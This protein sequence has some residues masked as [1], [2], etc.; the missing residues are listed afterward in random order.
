MGQ[1]GS[2][3]TLIIA[4]TLLTNV[5]LEKQYINTSLEA[6]RINA[7]PPGTKTQN[8]F[9]EKREHNNN[10]SCK[11]RKYL[12]LQLKLGAKWELTYTDFKIVTACYTYPKRIP[13]ISPTQ[14]QPNSLSVPAK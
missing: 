4:Q 3:A 7:T 9:V 1:S 8:H 6:K 11:A 10:E 12:P 14:F 2:R 13:I 5:V